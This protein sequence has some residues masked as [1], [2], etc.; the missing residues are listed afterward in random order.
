MLR[1]ILLGFSSLTLLQCLH[2]ELRSDGLETLDPNSAVFEPLPEL[3][4]SSFDAYF[5]AAASEA[6]IA[7]AVQ[8]LSSDELA[9]RGLGKKGL[10]TAAHYIANAFAATNL[11]TDFWDGLPY[12]Y[13]NVDNMTALASTANNNLKTQGADGSHT[14]LEVD[15]DFQPM[16]LGGNGSFDGEVAFV[17]YGISASG[18]GWSFD[19]YEGI[20]V[21]NKVVIVLRKEPQQADPASVF[22]GTSTSNYSLFAT[23]IRNAKTRG[24]KGMLLVNDYVTV[25]AD[26]E[27]SQGNLDRLPSYDAAGKFEG[28]I[29]LPTMFI[30]RKVAEA[31]LQ[32]HDANLT[33]LDLEKSI[34]RELKPASISLNNIRAAGQVEL[35]QQRLKTANVVT[36]LEG[37]GSLASE[38]I[39]IGAHYDHV[40]MGEY[41]SLAPGVT[42]IH[43]GADDNASG[44]SA[45]LELTKRFAARRDERPDNYRKIIFIAFSAEERGLLGSKYYVQ[46]PVHEISQTVTMINLDMI[47]RLGANRVIAYG[48]GSSPNFNT[49]VPKHAA[50]ASLSVDLQNPAMGPSDHQPFFDLGVPVLHFFTGIHPQY[51]RPSDDFEKIH[52]SGI[53][54]ITDMVY[55][56]VDE[57][58]RNAERPAYIRVPGRV[59]IQIASLEHGSLG[60]RLRGDL[61]NPTISSLEAAGP[62]EVAG[63]KVNDQ[64]VAIDQSQVENVP[65]LLEKMRDFAPKQKVTVTVLRENRKLEI[66]VILGHY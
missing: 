59:N 66:P 31:L 63:L 17:G 46:H 25:N 16:S 51:H 3:S 64:V 10:T 13:F 12:Q 61:T 39:V 50:N 41:G 54:R 26:S 37:K 8:Y 4:S 29:A 42:D 5:N 27:S 44:T 60:V 23:K 11:R 30:S 48:I 2:S 34:D 14:T 32:Q 43:N 15:K 62:A 18:P 35:K 1:K 33:L 47:G 7:E 19:E 20:D 58:A 24:A 38:A 6:R 36:S 52:T 55:Q 9:G 21:R 57:L 45:L 22:D 53:V 65:D 49:L 56:I 40:G 28:K